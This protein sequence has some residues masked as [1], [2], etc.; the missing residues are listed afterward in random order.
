MLERERDDAVNSQNF[1]KAA[2]KQSRELE[3]DYEEVGLPRESAERV[4]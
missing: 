2:S 1:A 4:L 3:Q